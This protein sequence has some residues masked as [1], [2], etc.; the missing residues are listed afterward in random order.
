MYALL[1]LAPCSLINEAYEV[2]SL[3]ESPYSFKNGTRFNPLRNEEL[4]VVFDEG[5]VIKVSDSTTKRI[6][7]VA[8]WKITEN[9]TLYF[10]PF[11][12]SPDMQG[13]RI[14]KTILQEIE[15]IAKSNNI[16]EIALSVVNHRTDLIPW[17]QS[18]GYQIIDT[19][20]WPE[21]EYHVLTK[22]SFFY[23]MKRPL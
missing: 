6:I 12:V 21:N 8:I 4:K 10:G 5:R 1:A 14:G 20:P 3:P 9:N 17:Y 15:S 2:E 7:G 22:E 13:K 23:N 11:A 16:N 19:S 18:L